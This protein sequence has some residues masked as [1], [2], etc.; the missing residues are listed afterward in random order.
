MDLSYEIVPVYGG[1]TMILYRE[2]QLAYLINHH[3]NPTNHPVYAVQ[4][5]LDS[6][7]L[8]MDEDHTMVALE[9][10]KPAQTHLGKG[11]QSIW[12]MFFD[13]SHSKEGSG[14]GVV[15]ISSSNQTFPFSFK[16]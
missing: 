12:K 16:L 11:N 14:P 7:V 15:I 5:D 4:T 13:G 10:P 8:H 9:K 1:K 3:D 6:F 2:N